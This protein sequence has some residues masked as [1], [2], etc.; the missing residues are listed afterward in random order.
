MEKEVITTTKT[1][2]PFDE[3]H[4]RLCPIEC[5]ADRTKGAGRCGVSSLKIAKYYLHPF[6]EP[7]ISF[8]NGSGTIFFTG[9]NLRCV[10]CQNYELSRAE[11]GKAITPKEL[12]DI[13]KE[14]E[15][16]GAENISLVTAGHLVP[17]LLQAFEIYPPKIPVVY[18]SSGYEKVETLMKIDP[19]IDIYLPDLKFYSPT[20]SKRYTG[21]EDYF[22]VAKEAVKFMSKKPLQMREDGKMLS[23]L[24]V[25][26]MVMPMGVSD[27]RNV[28]RWI[29]ENLSSDVFVSL[30]S[31][32]TPF[33]EIEKYPEL[34]RGITLREYSSVLDYANGLGIENLFAQELD[35]K[36]KKF[37]PTWDF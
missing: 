30:M 15:E 9:C 10:F 4:C 1:V 16:L 21:L 26:H 36:G 6:E 7:C 11:R 8:K 22:E 19:Y 17:Y 25:R 29:K 3:T 32:Y 23:G 2:L 13:F 35:S 24:I 34:K 27:S 33:G 5:N 28:L 14:L 12:A 31:Q 37:I 20:L 18:N